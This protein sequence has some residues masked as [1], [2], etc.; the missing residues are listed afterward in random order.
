MGEGGP[1]STLQPDRCC[2]YLE[3]RATDFFFVR[4]HGS[5]LA[6]WVLVALQASEGVGVEATCSRLTVASEI[7]GARR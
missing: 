2:S 4:R 6:L 3:S 7:S 1:K 5:D